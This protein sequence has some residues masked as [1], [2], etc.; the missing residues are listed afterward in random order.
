M[1]VI[2]E[3]DDIVRFCRNGLAKEGVSLSETMHVITMQNSQKSKIR[4][5][6]TTQTPGL[7]PNGVPRGRKPKKVQVPLTPA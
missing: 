7:T 1:D 3:W 2:L 5:K 6:F 4:I